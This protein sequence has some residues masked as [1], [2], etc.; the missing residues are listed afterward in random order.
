MSAGRV[1]VYRSTYLRSG[2]PEGER[3]VGREREAAIAAVGAVHRKPVE[4]LAHRVERDREHTSELLARERALV[5]SGAVRIPNSR[6]VALDAA[7]KR[8]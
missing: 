8:E 7:V 4:Q 2:R 1:R 5:L 3:A 6:V